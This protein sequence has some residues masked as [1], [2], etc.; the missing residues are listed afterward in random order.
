MNI[1]SLIFLGAGQM[2]E[3]L[4][5]GILAAKLLP[6]EG[7]VVSDI[8][9]SRVDELTSALGVRGTTSNREAV[10]LGDTVLL[11][12]KPSDVPTVLIDVGEILEPSQ[13]VISVAA[14][15][16]TASIEAGLG[17]RA[18]VIRVM[19][20][21]PALVGQGM[22][23]ITRGTHATEADESMALQL[24]GAVGKALTL[25]ERLMDAVT[26]LSGSGPAFVGI[27][28]DALVDGGVRVGIPRDVATTLALQTILGSAQM[29]LRENIHPATL[30]DMVT[31]PGG[32]T[33][34]GVHAMETGGVRAALINAVV[35]ATQR[36]KELGS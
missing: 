21:T 25:P 11:A 17:P 30:R 4:I 10:Q 3:A 35:A 13:L 27:V 2:A 23:V 33:I 1:S 34:A 36:S 19:P 26:G 24:F 14:G 12:T 32:T 31:S 6:P 8:R 9:P 28:A 7:V 18:R 22:A 5:R 15:V 16:T 20:N 29:M